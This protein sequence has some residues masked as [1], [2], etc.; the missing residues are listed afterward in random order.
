MTTTITSTKAPARAALRTEL[1]RGIAPW[2]GPAVALTLLVPLWSKAPQW[3]GSW[4]ETQSQLHAA[5]ALLGAPL[6]A[7]AACWQGGRE[8]RSAHRRTAALGPAQLLPRR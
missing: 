2:T 1:R 5:T 6:V 7:A 8:H 3:Q 4:G